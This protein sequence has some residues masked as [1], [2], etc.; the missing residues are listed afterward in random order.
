MVKKNR[1]KKI[2]TE[3]APW[4]WA[5]DGLPLKDAACF[6]CSLPFCDEES[7]GC[8]RKI[9]SKNKQVKND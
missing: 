8:N 7:E 9:E 3:R 4:T 2:Q 5:R 1:K 6:K